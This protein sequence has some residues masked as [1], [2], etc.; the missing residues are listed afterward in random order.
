MSPNYPNEIRPSKNVWVR[1]FNFFV[2]TNEEFAM[3]AINRFL[4]FSF[5][6]V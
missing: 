4:K 2:G 6:C 3:D 1:A 5:K